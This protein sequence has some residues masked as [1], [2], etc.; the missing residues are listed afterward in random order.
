MSFTRYFTFSSVRHFLPSDPFLYST[1]NAPSQAFLTFMAVLN[2]RTYQAIATQRSCFSPEILT[3]TMCQYLA[4]RACVG[5]KISRRF[6]GSLRF[7][8]SSNNYRASSL[9]LDQI[10]RSRIVTEKFRILSSF[11]Y[12]FQISL[13]NNRASSLY[14]ER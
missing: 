9:Y 14:P 10:S 3:E 13:N 1:L 11:L 7:P 8:I 12:R 6:A 5:I 2:Y 4:E